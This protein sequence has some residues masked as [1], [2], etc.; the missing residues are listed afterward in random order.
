[1]LKK[2]AAFYTLNKSHRVL[3]QN[4]KLY[5]RK[6][7][8]LQPER[9]E[10]IQSLLSN[11]QTAVAQKNP[12]IASRLA[13]SL[14]IAAKSLMPKSFLVKARDGIGAML[15]ALIV[16]LGIKLVGTLLMGALTIIPASIAKNIA[17]SIKAYLIASTL[18]GGIISVT[19]LCIAHMFSFLPGPSIIL[20]GVGVFL[21]SL[22][23]ARGT[24]SV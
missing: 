11:L 20:L 13:H 23:F 2:V 1:M 6:A 17:K 22:G 21:L 8:S 12:E 9:K 19:G 16:A 14:E 15:F 3:R 4:Y 7:A 24:Y 5:R 10:R 18:L